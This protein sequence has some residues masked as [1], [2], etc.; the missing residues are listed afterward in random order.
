MTS[1]RYLGSA[2][3]FLIVLGAA[4]AWLWYAIYVDRSR[5]VAA[6][7]VVIDRGSTFGEAARELEAAGVIANVTTFRFLA[8]W[9]GVEAAVR[10]GE[11]RFP[12]H[13]TQS[14]V[15][16]ALVTQGAQVAA[17]V[18][19]PEGFTAA[20]IA[21]RLQKEGIGASE[22]FLRNFTQQ[23]IV[24]DGTLR[25]AS[26]AFFFQAPIWCRSELHRNKSPLR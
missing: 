1:A 5:P 16:K 10:A 13:L 19:I 2:V 11:Y 3:A 22:P 18:T 9:R 24:V 14:E 7:Q 17:W 23:H 8:R 21:G 6:K 25:K 12:A 26:R 20:E 15:L 4:A